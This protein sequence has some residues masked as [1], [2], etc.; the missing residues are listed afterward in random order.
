[1][2]VFE[3]ALFLVVG[4]ALLTFAAI[5]FALS[6]HPLTLAN[7][8]MFVEALGAAGAVFIGLGA[9]GLY[10][11]HRTLSGAGRQTSTSPAAA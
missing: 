5:A 6:Q 3:S 2:K 8:G 1:M 7:P 9:R 10:R 11:L 4:S